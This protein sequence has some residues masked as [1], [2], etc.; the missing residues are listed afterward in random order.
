MLFRNPRGFPSSSPGSSRA[1]RT[2]LSR[3]GRRQT[4]RTQTQRPARQCSQQSAQRH[5][6]G[7]PDHHVR[8]LEIRAVKLQ[9]G[10]TGQP[11]E[12]ARRQS[13]GDEIDRKAAPQN[14]PAQQAGRQG[15]KQAG[16]QAHN[17]SRNE[18]VGLIIAEQKP[19]TRPA[20]PGCPLPAARPEPRG[21]GFRGSFR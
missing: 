4:S 1:P 14:Q 7:V 13:R 2:L 5:H 20:A 9:H 3:A 8:G 17:A 6:G 11:A 21:A 18:V 19:Q 10:H 12:R 15:V 16:K